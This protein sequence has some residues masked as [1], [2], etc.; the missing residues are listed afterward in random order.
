MA[1]K[2]FLEKIR[3]RLDPGGEASFGWMW[4]REE[5]ASGGVT[6]EAPV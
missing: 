4:G 6:T 5:R 2:D 1:R 3:L